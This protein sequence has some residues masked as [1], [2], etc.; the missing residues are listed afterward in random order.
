MKKTARAI[1]ILTIGILL[2]TAGTAQFGAAGPEMS[3]NAYTDTDSVHAGTEVRLAIRVKLSEGWHVNSNKPLDEF[4]IP[5]VLTLNED[6]RY[7]VVKIY[8]PEHKTI[9][10]SFS[11]DPMAVYEREFSLG[12]LLKLSDAVE[13]KPQTIQGKI[14]YQAC[15]D[16]QCAPP[17]ELALDI[18]ISLA[19][20]D[21]PVKPQQAE[22]FQSIAWDKEIA[23]PAPAANAGS[24]APPSSEAAGGDW[25]TLAEGF[26]VMGRLDGFAYADEFMAFIDRAESG[27]GT[28]ANTF[29]GMSWAWVVLLVLFGGLMLNLTP[30]VLPLIPINIAI[31][32]AGARAGSRKRGFALGA[33]YGFGIAVVYG[34]LGLVVVL[35]MSSMFGSLNASPWFNAAMF[36]LFGLLAL[37]MF[38]VFEIDFSKYQASIGIRKNE[39]GSL[40][41]AMTMGA[42]SALLAGACVAPVV[43]STLIQAQ[44]LYSQGIAIGLALPFLLGAGMALPWPLAGAGLSFLPKPGA[45][46]T[47][48]KQAFGV[49][50]I[51]FALYYGHLAYRLYADAGQPAA[52]AEGW[53]TSLEKGLA[54]AQAAGQPVLIDFWAT[55][56]KN[57]QVM[58]KTVLREPAVLKRLENYGKIKFQAETLSD[59][60]VQAV[61]EYF[62]VHGLPAY[63][64][65]RPR[66]ATPAPQ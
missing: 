43:I 48:V 60:R 41:V 8:Y 25:R 47:R 44:D 46:M 40:L 18:P 2:S 22:L 4:L 54:Q 57:C 32:G 38:D 17:A 11:P 52:S 30:C 35:G 66:G 58:D 5:T 42:I 21:Q 62:E 29:S 33:A 50:L 49:F 3:Y 15:N 65:L 31:I 51:V 13:V 59:P 23:A 36:V 12:V 53:E 26:E 55:W 19:G 24:T 63:I 56:C 39:H 34:L 37:A 10:L 45:W 9:K 16:K 20:K 27:Q 64:I 14:Q 6:P 61:N 28:V 7:S 1:W